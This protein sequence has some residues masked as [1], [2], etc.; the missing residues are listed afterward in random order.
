M[1]HCRISCLIFRA[2]TESQTVMKASFH[3]PDGWFGRSSKI[4]FPNPLLKMQ[5]QEP[6]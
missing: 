4:R 5:N 6:F 3:Y 2:I 1:W